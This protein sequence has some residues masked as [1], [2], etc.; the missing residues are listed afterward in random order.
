MEFS[1]FFFSIFR[2]I[3]NRVP[4]IVLSSPMFNPKAQKLVYLRKYLAQKFA[5]AR[6]AVD[7]PHLRFTTLADKD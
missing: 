5:A 6:C 7:K 4:A 2:Y 3:R 1:F